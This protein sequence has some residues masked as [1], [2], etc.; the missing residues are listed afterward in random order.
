MNKAR[1][2]YSKKAIKST[3][4]CS[5]GHLDGNP[6]RCA[7]NSNI[8]LSVVDSNGE[9]MCTTI[10]VGLQEM[11]AFVLGQSCREIRDPPTA[12]ICLQKPTS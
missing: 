8:P 4:L 2:R 7:Q 11:K 12:H 1:T 6:R 10:H 9:E 3:H 5:R